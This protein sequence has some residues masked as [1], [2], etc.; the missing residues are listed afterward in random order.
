MGNE[1]LYRIDKYLWGLYREEGRDMKVKLNEGI[2][3]KI[4]KIYLNRKS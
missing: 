3:N 2:N 1:Q 4:M